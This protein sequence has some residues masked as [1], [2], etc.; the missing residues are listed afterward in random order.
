MCGRI[1]SDYRYSTRLV[2]NNYPWPQNVTDAQ[3]ERVEEAVQGVLDARAQFLD[4]TLADLYD[5]NAMP[6]ALR[7]AHDA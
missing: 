6:P 5:P 3:R 2:Y 7:H 4:S 1:K